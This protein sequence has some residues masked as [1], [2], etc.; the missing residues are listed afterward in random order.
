[1]LSVATNGW[2]SVSRA[3]ACHSPQ[4]GRM[5]VAAALDS[6]RMPPRRIPHH[7]DR[8]ET[9]PWILPRWGFRERSVVMLPRSRRAMRPFRDSNAK[10]TSCYRRGG[11]RWRSCS[12]SSGQRAG[13]NQIALTRSRCRVTSPRSRGQQ[14]FRE[15]KDK[16]TRSSSRS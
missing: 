7:D 9:P 13:L 16:P 4:A 5:A 6:T 3:C 11:C 1:M 15:I 2:R 12:S 10:T 14:D 8:F